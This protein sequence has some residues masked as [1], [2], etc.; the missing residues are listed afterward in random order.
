MAY[1]ADPCHHGVLLLRRGCRDRRGDGNG[2][3]A[4][5][6]DERAVRQQVR[7]VPDGMF[8]AVAAAT[9]VTEQ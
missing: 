5:A 3:R 6:I 1:G 4:A 7:D 8:V 9:V 2:W